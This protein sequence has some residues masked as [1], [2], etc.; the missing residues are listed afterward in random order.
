[1]FTPEVIQFLK[2][3]YRKCDTESRGKLN[4]RQLEQLFRSAVNYSE[5]YPEEFEPTYNYTMFDS[6]HNSY[7]KNQ[8][9]FLHYIT[10]EFSRRKSSFYFGVVLPDPVAYSS[11]S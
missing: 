4:Q 2:K 3:I 11:A 6:G 5:D 8:Y 9:E 1:M 7:G 10:L